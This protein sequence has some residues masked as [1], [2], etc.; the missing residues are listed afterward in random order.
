MALYYRPVLVLAESENE[1]SATDGDGEP[2]LTELTSSALAKQ[3]LG[4]LKV[5]WPDH[6]SAERIETIHGVLDTNNSASVVKLL[7][8]DWSDLRHTWLLDLESSEVVSDHYWSKTHLGKM[9]KAPYV[10]VLN[11]CLPFPRRLS[12]K[13]PTK[14]EYAYFSAGLIGKTTS[15]VDI[16]AAIFKKDSFKMP[17]SDDPHFEFYGRQTTLDCQITHELLTLESDILGS[18]SDMLDGL[19]IAEDGEAALS[20]IRTSIALF[21]DT[22]GLAK[23]SNFRAR[24]Y[25]I[26]S[27]CK[28]KLNIRDMI[29]GKAS[30][31]SCIM[32]ALRGSCFLTDGI[33]GPIPKETQAQIDSFTSR[34]DGKLSFGSASSTAS[35]KRASP[36]PTR[37]NQKKRGPYVNYNAAPSQ[38]HSSGQYYSNPQPSPSRVPQ[39]QALFADPP[40]RGQ[41][42]KPRRGRGSKY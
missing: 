15:K 40:R 41:R 22:N 38:Y 42:G 29:L 6:F 2:S 25:A 13:F 33:F 8:K 32:D 39:S 21:Y 11:D 4:I 19:H 24:S 35:R 17:P 36:H 14:V 7:L 12:I 9:I 18:V 27:A 5:R 34:A 23:Q 1:G 3:K 16:P 10:P 20:D 26:T 28:A 30:G 37:G 31:D